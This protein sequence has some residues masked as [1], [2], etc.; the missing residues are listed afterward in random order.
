MADELEKVKREL[1]SAQKAISAVV[2]WDNARKE[3]K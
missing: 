2:E 1:D 3:T